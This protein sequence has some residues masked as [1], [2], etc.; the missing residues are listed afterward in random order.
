MHPLWS[1]LYSVLHTQYYFWNSTR[2]TF[3]RVSGTASG[4]G[5]DRPSRFP[6][7]TALPAARSGLRRGD[8]SRTDQPAAPPS[9]AVRVFLPDPWSTAVGSAALRSVDLLLGLRHTR[10]PARTHQPA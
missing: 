9:E 3:M 7:T 4:L 1:R 6:A 8:A 2:K 5:A 10:M